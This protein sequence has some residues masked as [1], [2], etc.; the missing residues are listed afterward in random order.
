[1]KKRSIIIIS[2]LLS[3]LIIFTFITIRYSYSLL[4]EGDIS[5]SYNFYRDNR[6]L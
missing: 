3:L 1:M 2:A 6:K 4:N 5:K